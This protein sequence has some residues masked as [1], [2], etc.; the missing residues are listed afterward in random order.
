[1]LKIAE[2]AI[3]ATLMSNP[4]KINGPEDNFLTAY[5][6][7]NKG[8]KQAVDAIEG[9]VM[10]IAGPGTG[11]TQILTLRIANILRQ[12]DTKPEQILALTFT[13]SGAQA[14]RARLATFIG[15]DAYHVP[16]H[17]FHSFAGEL[18]R[19]YPDSYEN[20]VGGRPASEIEK[21]RIV[22]QLLD[23]NDYKRLRPSGDH[24]YYVR[25]I[26]GA[27][28]TLK[29]EYVSADKFAEFI[30]EQEKQLLGIEKIH[31]KGAHKGK[32]R[33]EYQD[34]EKHLERNREL[35]SLYRLYVAMLKEQGLYDFEDMILD[36]IKALESSEDMLLD[37][38]EQ[39]QYLLAD[40]HQDVNQSQNRLIELI[41]S[42]HESPNVFVVGDEKQAI[43][44]FQGASLEN[45]L[46]FEDAY[47]GATTISLVDNYRSDQRILDV[48][49]DGIET[50]DVDL[51]KLRVP[52]MAANTFDTLVAKQE[53][54]HIAIEN[55]WVVSRVREYQ[56]AGVSWDEI[57]V[58]VR[59]N[60]EVEQFA[61][62]MR[63]AEIPV[64]P[65]A[66]GDVL[67]HPVINNIKILLRVATSPLDESALVELLHAPYWNI[68]VSDLVM[69][70]MSR[71]YNNRIINIIN[72]ESALKEIGIKDIQPFL[73]IVSLFEKAK[74]KS[75]TETP[76][77]VLEYLLRESGFVD[78]VVKNHP[79]EGVRVVRRLYDE[80]E[81]MVLQGEVKNLG[82]ILE[83]LAIYE[84]YNLSL[85]APF[86]Q[87][88]TKAVSVMTAHKAKGLEFE[89][90]MIP[91]L[92]DN[93]WGTKLRTSLFTLPTTKH[94]LE[95]TKEVLKE[96]A[97]DDG[98]RLF[99]VALT[100]AKRV[101]ECSHSTNNSEGRGLTPSRFL[102]DIDEAK[103]AKIET[104]D[105]EKEFD[106]VK[107]IEALPD[108]KLGSDFLKLA[109][110]KNGWSAT[111]F[112]NYCKSPWEYI[113]KNVLRF[114]AIKT[115]SLLFGTAVHATL[116]Q[117]VQQLAE[118]SEVSDSQV[119]E[120]LEKS[121]GKYPLSVTE[122]TR[123]LEKG[124]EALM[125]YV[126][127]L[128][129][130]L[131][132]VVKTEYPLHAVLS[133]GITEF[134]EVTLTGNFDRLD[135]DE[136]G[137]VVLVIDYKT[138]K[139]K[140][141]NDIEG[142]TKNST[143]S[144]KRQLVFYALLLS[145]HKDERFHCKTGVLSFVQP[146]KNGKIH[147]ESFT[148]TD[149]EVEELRLQIIEATRVVVTGECLREVCDPD[150]CEY[151][152]LIGVLVG[153]DE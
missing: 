83:H 27:I 20:I 10:V 38:Q 134:P 8:Q 71:S 54:S 1:M 116:D 138:G 111:S 128:K 130:T 48:A 127:E 74:V 32:V 135:F 12:T 136:K 93:S 94:I 105:F 115:P 35:L 113:Y 87:T 120:I 142:N 14:M 67:K 139:S 101:L 86:I 141:R 33:G 37:V 100:R 82:S 44:R 55:D 45:F 57:A 13:D 66:D 81:M 9:P 145:L 72:D 50:D 146:D 76:L 43:Y 118:G 21:I 122:F 125:A 24:R 106:L 137:N 98:R 19:N 119:K 29:K 110:A 47:K 148:I 114:P 131:P 103:I 73:K 59:T 143:G 88:T 95:D 17:T 28:S 60:R 112:N 75:V 107:D 89:V 109:L 108:V 6:T 68:P 92:T 152:H 39:Y 150:Q 132:K 26:L 62:L 79:Y 56:E 36:T 30:A 77:Q 69:L 25:P 40:E 124:F 51:K 63:K 90:V 133:T 64:A 61:T 34:A 126:P 91:H 58:I 4:S 31:E 140:T 23:S 2:N 121:L 151:C 53:F 41:A 3:L 18:I 52:L 80:V 15:N 149:E 5:N 42:Y 7:L 104:G 147:E 22:E 153:D 102:A 49:Q 99:Y 70:L 117:I 65:S 123:Q 85:S 96:Q 46:Y 144:Y 97:E 129:K 84:S 11:K 78:Y 16:I